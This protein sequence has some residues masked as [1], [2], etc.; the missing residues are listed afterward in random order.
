MFSE[1]AS[2]LRIFTAC[3]VSADSIQVKTELQQ[4]NIFNL[5]GVFLITT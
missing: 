4:I 2:D 3:N 5:S 1:V